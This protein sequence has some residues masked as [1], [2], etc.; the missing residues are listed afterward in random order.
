M[1]SFKDWKTASKILTAVLVLY[2]LILGVGLYGL[3]NASQ[4][5]DMVDRMYEKELL[6]TSAIMDANIHLLYGQRALLRSLSRK[7]TLKS[8]WP[9]PR[10]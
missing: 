9:K 8:L 1:K 6:G 7:R 4:L 5:N 10:K 3:R 2:V